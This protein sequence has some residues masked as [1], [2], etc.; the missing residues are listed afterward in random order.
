MDTN[1]IR[2]A[3]IGCGRQAERHSKYF[4]GMGDGVRVV[5]TADTDLERARRIAERHGCPWYSDYREVLERPDVNTVVIV[6]PHALLAEV[7][8]AA[9]KAG[10]QILCEKPM[11]IN[12]RQGEQV[13][14]AADAAGVLLMIGGQHRYRAVVRT[15]QQLVAAGEIG[16]PY[17]IEEVRK[18]P[19]F[20]PGYP[21]WYRKVE[22]TGGG[23][24]QNSTSHS[25]DLIRFV[26]QR[27][28]TAVSAVLGRYVHDIEGED[29]G[30]LTLRFDDGSIGVTIQSWKAYGSRVEVTGTDGQLKIEADNIL[31]V[32][33][34]SGWKEVART[35]EGEDEREKLDR[36]F[37]RCL[38]E[39]LVPSPSGHE[40]MGVVR[41]IEAAYRSAEVKREVSTADL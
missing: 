41:A 34:G 32:N 12:V 21:T 9:A 29:S 26:M 16:R 17:L 2:V 13:V 20:G 14:G 11:A 6:L 38:R 3:L 33:K 24:L 8:I 22:L 15:M 39:D 31:Y 19:G 10:K 18:T 35:P 1:E 7:A 25:L 40:Y 36:Y 27:E 23:V 37:V 5:A 30:I 4:G 28:I